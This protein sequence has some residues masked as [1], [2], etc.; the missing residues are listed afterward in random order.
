MNDQVLLWLFEEL[1]QGMLL[2]K[3]NL[4]YYYVKQ[5]QDLLPE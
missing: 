2:R 3:V 4:S 1:Q 5:E